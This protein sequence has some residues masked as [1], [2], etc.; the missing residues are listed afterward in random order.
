MQRLDKQGFGQAGLWAQ[1]LPC[2]QNRMRVCAVKFDM[3][4]E[5]HGSIPASPWILGLK[6]VP[7]CPI[8]LMGWMTFS[9]MDTFFS[10]KVTVLQDFTYFDV[11]VTLPKK[12]FQRNTPN[13]R[14]IFL[15]KGFWCTST[16]YCPLLFM[17]TW[18]HIQSWSSRAQ[19]AEIA[20]GKCQELL[21]WHHWDFCHWFH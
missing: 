21:H 5:H 6:M 4:V 1:L 8:R 14:A 15:K 7:W 12:T 20:M 17:Q 11:T 13:Q 10:W 16:Y 9:R 19:A 2:L 18:H 3:E